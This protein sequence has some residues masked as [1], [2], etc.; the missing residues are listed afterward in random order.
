MSTEWVVNVIDGPPED[1][2]EISVLRND[3]AHGKRSYGG[4]G[5][6]L[7][8]AGR[9]MLVYDGNSSA[10]VPEVWKMQLALAK[11]LASQLNR[12]EKKPGFVADPC[13][14]PVF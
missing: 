4:L 7:A 12:K 3:N 1:C 8:G 2:G 5:G 14:P 13:T 10:I 6:Q 11:R 9:K